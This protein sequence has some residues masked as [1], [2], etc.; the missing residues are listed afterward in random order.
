MSGGHNAHPATRPGGRQNKQPRPGAS[1]TPQDHMLNALERFQDAAGAA[2]DA[3]GAD[4][5]MQQGLDIMW[6]L[7]N[8][9]RE[10]RV[11]TA[12]LSR[13]RATGQDG[14]PDPALNAPN[15]QISEASQRLDAAR[16]LTRTGQPAISAGVKANMARGVPAG[17]DPA[18]GGPAVAAAHAMYKALRVSGGIWH[19]PSG[20][21]E[22]R[23][24]I[25]TETMAAMASMQI[26]AGSLAEGAPKPFGTTI[27][28]IARNFDISCG[29]LRESL[30]CSATGNYQPGTEDLAVQ[31]RESYPLFSEIEKPHSPRPGLLAREQP[32]WPRPAFPRPPP[33]PQP[34]PQ[35]S[36]Q[37]PP[38]T[39]AAALSPSG[40]LAHG[41]ARPGGIH[42]GR[43]HPQRTPEPGI[44]RV[45]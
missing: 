11:F 45:L 40:R 21:A 24:Q 18:H 39:R 2:A 19:E 41:P 32:A 1:A 25:V 5:T 26:A 20:A 44:A 14:Q 42:D 16:V 3:W 37:T 23:D 27:A 35:P 12:M 9:V 30:I 36:P 8:I 38:F 34:S 33:A 22:V 10:F 31:I 29:H 43:P 28:F 17:G 15:E 6:M 13:Y 4:L 7:G